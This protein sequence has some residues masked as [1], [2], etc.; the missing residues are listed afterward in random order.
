M[1]TEAEKKQTEPPE[2]GWRKQNF[3]VFQIN[4]KLDK[5]ENLALELIAVRKEI[6]E[7]L[8][9]V[10]EK[11]EKNAPDGLYKGKL[12]GWLG[13][14]VV[15]TKGYTLGPG[16]MAWNPLTG[17]HQTTG[18]P[19]LYFPLWN[20]HNGPESL[21]V[22]AEVFMRFQ[23]EERVRFC[24]AITKEAKKYGLSVKPLEVEELILSFKENGHSE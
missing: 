10:I 23:D 11:Q 7:M 19:E 14:H 13:K 3:N 15:R 4:Q 20:G 2:G 17:K 22:F 9:I 18:D 16:S 24:S 12:L 1:E 8:G 5:M 6:K 21:D